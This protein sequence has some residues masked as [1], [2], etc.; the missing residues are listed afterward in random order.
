[1][2]DGNDLIRVGQDPELSKVLPIYRTWQEDAQKFGF[3]PSSVGLVAAVGVSLPEAY[4][5][6]WCVEVPERLVEKSMDEVW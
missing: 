4:P 2:T 5:E 6:G 3:H 1:M